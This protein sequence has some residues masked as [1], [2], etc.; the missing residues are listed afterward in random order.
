MVALVISL[1]DFPKNLGAET[2]NKRQIKYKWSMSRHGTGIVIYRDSKNNPE[3]VVWEECT[4]GHIKSYLL[5]VFSPIW[6]HYRT[7]LLHICLSALCNKITSCEIILWKCHW[8]AFLSDSFH[9]NCIKMVWINKKIPPLKNYNS[10]KNK[11]KNI[12]MVTWS[13]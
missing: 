11:R 10:N 5:H 7:L 2:T 4:E 12:Y 1:S 6:Q 9:T 3:N 8:T 13:L